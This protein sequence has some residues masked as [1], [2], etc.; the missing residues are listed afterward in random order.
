MR[1]YKFS[2]L[3]EF[4]GMRC[5]MKNDLNKLYPQAV[6]LLFVALNEAV[7][8]AIFHGN[9]NGISPNIE[10]SFFKD[11]SDVCMAVRHDGLAFKGIEVS[12]VPQAEDFDEHG[13]G[14][15]IIK[16]CID[17]FK[18]TDSG[19]KIIMRKKIV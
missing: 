5:V 19:R 14:I 13:R 8:N 7:N 4:A 16:Y 9:E 1:Q 12:E 17:S 18:Y 11:G 15:E 10:V 3:D 6:E 2:S